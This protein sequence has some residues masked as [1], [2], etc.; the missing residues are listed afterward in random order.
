M[1]IQIYAIQVSKRA[2]Y[3]A[4]VAA[5]TLGSLLR[6]MEALAGDVRRC[7]DF[8]QLHLNIQ[9][10]QMDTEGILSVVV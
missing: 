10:G 6:T 3:P 7:G 4:C 9:S 2:V 5:L 1:S 8:T